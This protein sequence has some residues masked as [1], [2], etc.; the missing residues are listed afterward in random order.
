MEQEAEVIKLREGNFFSR[1]VWTFTSPSRLFA[2]I[3]AKPAFLEPWVWVAIFSLVSAHLYFPIQA[4]IMKMGMANL[5][6]EQLEKSLEA[7]EK[8]RL[9]GYVGA[10][11][12]PLIGLLVFS[13]LGYIA[14]ALIS[15]SSSYKSYLT[16]FSY[17]YLIPILGGL[18]S[19][20]LVRLRGVESIKSVRDAQV[21]F[22]LG[23][24]VPEG[25]KLLSALAASL[26]VF[27]I[28][29]FILMGLGVGVLFRMS[30]NQVI[31]AIVPLWLIGFVA[32]LLGFHFAK[33][34]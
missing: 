4:A 6:P 5:S 29:F 15:E 24:L 9:L 31:A 17:A 34:S 18:L 22:G 16:L 23:F 26:E 32:A 2:D 33:V 30:R 8:F 3:E 19:A 7:M 14:V 10:A 25:S 1:F 20:I 28:W 13:L 12:V 27:D 11:I 21:S